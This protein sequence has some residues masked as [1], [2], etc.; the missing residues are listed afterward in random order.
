MPKDWTRWRASRALA[1]SIGGER[2]E[3]KGTRQLAFVDAPILATPRK[4]EEDDDTGTHCRASSHSAPY[5]LRGSRTRR[6]T[7]V[8]S[9]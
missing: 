4:G 5:P 3:T 9:R 1:W 8:P 2:H 7:T 6:V